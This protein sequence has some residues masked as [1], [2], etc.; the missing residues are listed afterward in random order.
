[1]ERVIQMLLS[2][3]KEMINL[4]ITMLEEWKQKGELRPFIEVY[5]KTSIPK[6]LPKRAKRI[7]VS[8]IE[9]GSY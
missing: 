7:I 5:L 8:E 3:D 9:S 2:D 6:R 4:C 1:M